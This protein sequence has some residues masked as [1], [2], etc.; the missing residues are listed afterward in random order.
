ML[1]CYGR[2]VFN[3]SKRGENIGYD[4][5]LSKKEGGRIAGRGGEESFRSQSAN[6]QNN[7]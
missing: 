4:T 5:S 7:P 2:K 1:G 3:E 6:G